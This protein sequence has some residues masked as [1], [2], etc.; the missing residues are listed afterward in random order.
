MGAVLSVLIVLLMTLAP[1]KRYSPLS[2]ENDL[3]AWTRE[4]I[5][6]LGGEVAYEEFRAWAHTLNDNSV[7]GHNAAHVFGRELYEIEGLSSFTICDSDLSYGCMHEFTGQAIV[8][9]GTEIV[10][11]LVSL[12]GR[13]HGEYALSCY[14]GIGHG[15]QSF[16]G[17]EEGD[18]KKAL[19]VCSSSVKTPIVGSGCHGGAFMEWNLK[20][21]LGGDAVVRKGEDLYYPCNALE[22]E[23]VPTCVFR[24]S[25]WW[26][27]VL[28]SFSVENKYGEMGGLCRRFTEE[29]L[30]SDTREHHYACFL[31][32]G[33]N[34][35]SEVN[36]D[37]D[38]IFDLC[39]E[40]STTDLE[41]LI[42]LSGASGRTGADESLAKA[43]RM[44]EH[45]NGIE[46]D[47]CTAFAREDVET[48]AELQPRIVGIR[49]F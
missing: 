25:Q 29:T 45:F 46:Y 13:E 11:H 16:L 27:N 28:T 49:E 12:C 38:I 32:I 15:V 40:A 14:H 31:G 34:A 22:D 44:C 3:E 6:T 9:H 2:P 48:L 7:E 4:R 35:S 10:A 17:Y 20:T 39:R 26:R 21:I 43:L 19:E 1:E 47:Y 8:Q 18:L 41:L 42:C 30:Y 24:Q 23:Y 33:H 37:A 36:H 5:A